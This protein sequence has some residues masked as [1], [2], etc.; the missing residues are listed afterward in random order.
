[1]NIYWKLGSYL[2]VAVL[3]VGG[4]LWYGHIQYTAGEAANQAQNDSNILILQAANAKKTKDALDQYTNNL[5]EAEQRTKDAEYSRTK[6]VANANSLQHQIAVLKRAASTVPKDGPKTDGTGEA[7]FDV[8]G[9]CV[10]NLQGLAVEAGRLAD[11]VTGLQ[12]QIKILESD[13]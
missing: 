6:L 3:T 9:Q 7:G 13:K 10:S 2:L 12:E 8:L 4:V 5:K 11:K 1:M